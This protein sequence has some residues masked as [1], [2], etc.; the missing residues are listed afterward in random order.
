MAGFLNSKLN[1]LKITPWHSGT[2]PWSLYGSNPT[3]H[4]GWTQLI[5]RAAQ[6]LQVE[7]NEN[8]RQHDVRF[9]LNEIKIIQHCWIQLWLVVRCWTK[10]PNELKHCCSHLR[11]KEKLNQ[12]HSTGWPN[13]LNFEYIFEFNHLRWTPSLSRLYM[14]ITSDSLQ[15]VSSTDWASYKQNAQPYSK[16][17]Y[18][19]I[20]PQVEKT[21]QR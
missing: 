18:G 5:T 12:H 7:L 2:N 14:S 4:I 1:W 11:T 6:A 8:K 15:S 10:K 9:S 20:C 16:Q 3:A 13:A 17:S 19:N 21:Q